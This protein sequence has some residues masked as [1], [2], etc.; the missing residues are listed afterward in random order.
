MVDNTCAKDPSKPTG[1]P[2]GYQCN[3]NAQAPTDQFGSVTVV[4]LCH[5]TGAPDAFWGHSFPEGQTGA[6]GVA[7]IELVDCEEWQ[8]SLDRFASWTGFKLKDGS[9]K[10]V[11]AKSGA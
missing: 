9:Q 11:V 6:V 10:Q 3:Q 4:D 7:D 1:G 8:G 5:D 2:N